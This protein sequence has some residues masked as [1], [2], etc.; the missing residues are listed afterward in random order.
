[1]LPRLLLKFRGVLF[2]VLVGFSLASVLMLWT[3]QARNM[4]E[5]PIVNYHA[6]E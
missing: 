3:N 4:M 2:G 6:G 1:M 5:I